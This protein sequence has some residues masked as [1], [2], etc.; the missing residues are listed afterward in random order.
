MSVRIL[1]D[2]I[3]KFFDDEGHLVATLFWGDRIEE[4]SENR[5]QLLTTKWNPETYEYD[6]VER[7][8]SAKKQPLFQEEGVFKARFIDV[9]QG[10]AAIF[11]NRDGGLTLIDGGMGPWIRRYLHRAFAYLLAEGP[12][13]LDAIVVT[14]GDAD[15]YDGLTELLTRKV[16]GKP[17][18]TTKRIFH[19]GLTKASGEELDALG[20]IVEEGPNGRPW[21]V[22]LVDDITEVD[23]AELNRP[24]KAWKKALVALKERV[25]DLEVRRIAVGDDGAFDFLGVDTT[26]LGPITHEVE[27][28]P[29]LEYLKGPRGGFEIGHTINGHSIVLK[30]DVGKV[31]ILFGADLNIESEERLLAHAE[32]NGISLESEVLKVPHHG[33]HE[34]VPTLL[35]QIAPV[36]SIV[37]SGDQAIVAGSDHIHPRAGLVGA[38]GKYSRKSVERPLVYVT[39]MV[40]YFRPVNRALEIRDD[41]NVPLRNA[42]EKTTFGIVHVRTDGRRVLVATH[43]GEAKK[44]ESYVFTIGDDGKITFSDP[45]TK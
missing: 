29:A 40:A 25:P 7:E 34:F 33:S 20:E 41:G 35:E 1:K 39:E 31:R 36:V 15:H 6:L 27:G 9:G 38:L 4:I 2:D 23:D 24:F 8:V 17:L 22:G 28:K 32:E 14:H 21:I 26:V 13:P 11:E 44:K 19:N 42:H 16:G 18:V 30:L 37:S 12:I 10:D 45:K 3:V 43:S 5:F